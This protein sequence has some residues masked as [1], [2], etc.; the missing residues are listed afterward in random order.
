MEDATHIGNVRQRPTSFS[1]V[2]QSRNYQNSVH[3]C[4]G[5]YHGCILISIQSMLS[6]DLILWELLVHLSESSLLLKMWYVIFF[7]FNGSGQ[8]E[9]L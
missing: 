1:V 4:Y 3:S 9:Y 2:Q 6:V 7:T 5:H 8:V